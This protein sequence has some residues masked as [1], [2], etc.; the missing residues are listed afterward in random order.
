[1]TPHDLKLRLRA[2]VA[3]RR[4][5]R[6][7]TDELAFHIECET[8]KQIAEGVDAAEARRLALARFGPV[9]LAADQCRDERGIS[10]FETLARDLRFALRTLRRAPLVAL[11]VVST[12]AL[13]L[14]VVAV[15][16][17]FFNAFFFKVDAV[18]NPDELFAVE[19]PERP[20]SRSEIPFTRLEYEDLRRETHVFTDVAAFRPSFPTRIDGRS[21][22][23]MFVSG[24]FFDM[25]GVAAARGRTLTPADEGG[26]GRSV[27][28]L[29]HQ[30][31][32]NLFASDPAVVGR[33]LLVNGQP[34]EVAGVMPDGF[35]G[36]RQG[37]PHYWAPLALVDQFRPGV[38]PNQGWVDV[39]GRLKPGTSQDAAAAAL[40]TWASAQPGAPERPRGGGPEGVVPVRLRESRGV[41]SKDRTEAMLVFMPIFFAFGLIL[42]IGCANVANLLLARGLSRHREIGVRLSLGATRGRIVRQLLTEN[43]L[44]AL[45]AAVL[46]FFVSRA[47]LA[48]S[49]HMAMSILPPEFVEP[50]DSA[51]LTVPA[52]DWRVLAF[53]FGGAFVSTVMFGLVPALH[54]TRLELVRAMRGEVTRDARPSRVRQVLIGTQVTASALL[55]VCAAVFLRSTYSAATADVGVRTDD[56]VVVSAISEP[57]RPA[58]IHAIRDHLSTAAVAASWPQPTDSGLS[59]AASVGDT[60]LAVGCKLVS[61]EY[62]DLLGINVSRGRLFAPDE[63]SPAAGVVVISDA[64]AQRFWPN[65]DGL[66]QMLRL[67]GASGGSADDKGSPQVPARLFTVIGVVRD[68][69]SALR[70]FDFGYSGIYLPTTPEQARTSLVL[71]VH[72]DPDTARRALLDGLTRVDPAIAITTMKMMAGL[73]AAILGVVFWMAV[74]LGSL[75][76]ALTVSGL[77]GVLSYLVEQRRTEIGV[78]MALG[79]TPR[80]IVTLVVSQSMRP[81]AIGVVAGG[82]LAAV[83]AIVLLSTPAAAMIGTM[84]HAFDPVAYA[85]S[86]GIIVATC[87]VAAFFPAR[88]AAHIDPI[89]TLRAD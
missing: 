79:A 82:G 21:A 78:R 24:N 75:A 8:R 6:E 33:E 68:V 19:R 29:S 86:L 57:A 69:H 45:V 20:G 16:F 5:E 47:L 17:T 63:R 67:G 52:G 35:R 22:V 32:E 54:S 48:G 18:R 10:F 72:G 28:V 87:L 44:L 64:V 58:M 89:A 76:L 31:W 83:T 88:R 7:L 25:L 65:G 46:A 1:M 30:G 77:F 51:D 37:P 49:L 81:I 42:M 70:V 85:V 53:L 84:V 41:L 62:F 56:T 4:V 36:L 14:G 74:I 9:P 12:I 2:L 11:T 38:K 71:R 40:T 34:Y 43:L 15:A 59:T 27:V 13:G 3:P 60:T 26:G 66:G 50:T 23:G 55:L 61:P 73:D 80:D 39:V